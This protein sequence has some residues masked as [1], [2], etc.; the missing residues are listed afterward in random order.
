[1]NIILITIIVIVII[2]AIVLITKFFLEYKVVEANSTKKRE[3]EFDK[4]LQNFETKLNKFSQ[5]NDEKIVSAIK[6]LTEN[7]NKFND[8]N[9]EKNNLV[10]L[11]SNS[12]EENL[13]YEDVV[14]SIIAD[15]N[16]TAIEF[17]AVFLKKYGVNN[18]TKELLTKLFNELNFENDLIKN[19]IK[20]KI[21]QSDLSKKQA[22]LEEK[23]QPINIEVMNEKNENSEVHNLENNEFDFDVLNQIVS[24][25]ESNN[26]IYE[27]NHTSRK[28]EE[29]EN[30]EDEKVILLKVTAVNKLKD[31]ENLSTN[32]ACQQVGIP[33]ATYYKYFKKSN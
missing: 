8:N 22:Q 11:L 33:R 4:E 18:S 12:Y 14:M 23:N 5:L 15:L 7:I 2:F 25:Q 19:E 16:F 13:I 30:T 31:E 9:K 20:N 24:D 17:K 28:V 29:E 27:I 6:N 21:F 26:S 32:L 10:T 3:E 1:M